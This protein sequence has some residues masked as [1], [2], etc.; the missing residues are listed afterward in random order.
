[1][2]YFE[3]YLTLIILLSISSQYLI[4][5]NKLYIQVKKDSANIDY[6]LKESF[7]YLYYLKAGILVYVVFLIFNQLYLFP[8]SSVVLI[9]G[10]SLALVEILVTLYIIWFKNFPIL[11]KGVTLCY[12]CVI[13]GGFTFCNYTSAAEG[14]LTYRPV[15]IQKFQQYFHGYSSESAEQSIVAKGIYYR[16]S[17]D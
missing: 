1:M 9:L 4:G 6:H 3:R 10:L 16:A 15:G 13:V 14:I 12:R 11:E 7:I 8:F 5:K 17:I 2:F